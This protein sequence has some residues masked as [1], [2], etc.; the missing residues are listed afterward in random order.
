MILHTRDSICALTSP[1]TSKY[2]PEYSDRVRAKFVS[3]Q[4]RR[5]SIRSSDSHGRSTCY[6]HP[7]RRVPFSCTSPLYSLHI[8]PP[9]P[10]PLPHHLCVSLANTPSHRPKHAS[11]RHISQERN[12]W[13]PY[14]GAFSKKYF[15]ANANVIFAKLDRWG[16]PSA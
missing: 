3:E 11:A 4:F 9:S 7:F 14:E 15:V 13:N 8:C 16:F 10:S 1:P 2:L 5:N 6:V 12:E